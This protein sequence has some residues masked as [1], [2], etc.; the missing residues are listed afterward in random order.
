[1]DGSVT[2]TL[3]R[4]QQTD[5]DK[6]LKESDSVDKLSPGE[7]SKLQQDFTLSVCIL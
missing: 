1:M 3:S 4:N 5:L 2:E 7:L 6:A